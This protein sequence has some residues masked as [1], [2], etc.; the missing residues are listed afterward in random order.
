MRMFCRKPFVSVSG[1]SFLRG[2]RYDMSDATAESAVRAGFAI[3]VEEWLSNL[4]AEEG[5]SISKKRG[6]PP[7]PPGT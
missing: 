4:A 1:A 6:R 2:R 5:Y 7:K 3:P